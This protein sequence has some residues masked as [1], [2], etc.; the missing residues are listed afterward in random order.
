MLTIAIAAA[1][2]EEKTKNL[3]SSSAIVSAKS[4]ANNTAIQIRII[5][6]HCLVTKELYLR[7]V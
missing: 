6:S 3:S 5:C 2:I 1:A 7:Q 4:E